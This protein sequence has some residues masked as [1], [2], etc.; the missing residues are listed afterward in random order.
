MARVVLDKTVSCQRCESHR[1]ARVGGKT[2]DMSSFRLG[3]IDHHGYV[4][5]DVGVGSGDYFDFR[6]CLDC[7]QIQ[8]TWPL[9]ES[10]IEAGDEEEE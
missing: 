1:V 9:P 6:Y 2:S 4:V 3:N 7:G 8:G 10:E 5:G